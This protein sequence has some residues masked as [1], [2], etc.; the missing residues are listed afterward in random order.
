MSRVEWVAPVYTPKQVD[1][2]GRILAETSTSADA[3]LE[4]LR[5]VDNWRASHSFPLN[6][7]QVGLRRRARQIDDHAIVAQRLKRLSSIAFKLMRY[8]EMPLSRMQ[9]I[10]GCRA[11]VRSVTNVRELHK[12]FLQS[13]LKHKLV[14]TKDYIAE[15]KA[16]G[17]RS[18][19]LIYRYFSDKKP[20]YNKL[21]AEIQ[22]RTQ[23]QHAWATAVETVGTFLDQSLKSS[24]GSGEWLTFF[25]LMGSAFAL[26]ERMPIVPGTPG[27]RQTLLAE[28]RKL[29]KQLSVRSTL[30][31]Y[32]RAVQTEILPSLREAA[33]FLLTLRPAEGSV[34]V[35]S[36]ARADLDRANEQ[37]LETERQIQNEPGSQAVLVAAESIESLLKAYPNYFLDT[38][39]F[40]NELSGLLKS[41]P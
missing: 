37:Y 4:A 7:F 15:P 19:H 10:G 29:S 35:T 32:Q 13:N 12:T 33:Y 16:S 34:V 40:L 41:S 1:H 3:Y 27:D 21:Q 24:Q 36:F 11:V 18:L 20:T 38:T 5:V 8:P 14:R 2:A 22:I 30:T 9:D 28:I 23:L 6:T 25:S 17:Y 39:V 26:R 31:N